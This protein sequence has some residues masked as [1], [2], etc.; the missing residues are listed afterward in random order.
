LAG[1]TGWPIAAKKQHSRYRDDSAGRGDTNRWLNATVIIELAG[2]RWLLDAKYKCEFG[3]ESRIDR[4]QMCAYAVH[5][6]ADRATLVYPTDT[7]HGTGHRVLLSTRVGGKPLIIDSV[8]LP[9]AAGPVACRSALALIA[10]SDTDL[11]PS[12]T[13]Q[14][15]RR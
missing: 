7:P 9:F 15:G 13:M 3:D 10:S 4:F 8:A 11:S 6:D 2:T 5:F 12:Q 1:E 14:P